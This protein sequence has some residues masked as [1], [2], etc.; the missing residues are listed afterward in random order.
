MADLKS[1]RTENLRALVDETEQTLEVLRDELERREEQDQHGEIEK[2]DVHMKNAELS[3]QSI[4][5]FISKML[6]EMRTGK[7]D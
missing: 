3:L 6:D 1:I 5:D 7:K 4:R 2:L